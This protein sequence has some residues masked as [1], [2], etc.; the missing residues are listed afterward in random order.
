[1][2]KRCAKILESGVRCAHSAVSGSNFCRRHKP[3]SPG[4]GQKGMRMQKAA[5]R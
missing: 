5:K 1:M 4:K 3:F 2:A